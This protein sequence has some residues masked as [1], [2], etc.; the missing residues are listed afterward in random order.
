MVALRPN[1]TFGQ[2]VREVG[3]GAILSVRRQMILDQLVGCVTEYL[4]HRR[5]R[6]S[7]VLV[8]QQAV[9]RSNC[10]L[11]TLSTTP[12]ARD[13]SGRMSRLMA[14]SSPGAL[15]AP[16]AARRLRFAKLSVSSAIQSVSRAAPRQ[17]KAP[18][19]SKGCWFRA[20]LVNFG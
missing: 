6:L 5:L 2:R 9:T 1:A 18:K 15:L 4:A 20:L 16:Q 17:W 7:C 8:M 14:T 13:A 12:N 3:A 19:A 11:H 10:R